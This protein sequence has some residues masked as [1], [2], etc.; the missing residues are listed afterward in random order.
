MQR[1]PSRFDQRTFFRNSRFSHDVSFYGATFRH[2]A[3]F[4]STI[5]DGDVSLSNLGFEE[6]RLT[7]YGSRIGGT[8]RVVENLEGESQLRGQELNFDRTN[9]SGLVFSAGNRQDPGEQTGPSLTD[10]DS[11]V[12]FRQANVGLLEIYRTRFN[13]RADFSIAQLG[14]L[15]LDD[16]EFSDLRLDWPVG[17]VEAPDNTFASV[18]RSYKSSGDVINERLARLD[19]YAQRAQRG[20][21][22]DRYCLSCWGRLG[23]CKAAW[24]TTGYF[25][26]LKR[27]FYTGLTL[28]VIFAVI[29]YAFFSFKRIIIKIAKPIELKLRL[30]ETPTLSHGEKYLPTRYR[31]GFKGHLVRIWYSVL[32]SLMTFAKFGAGNLRLDPKITSVHKWQRRLL[33]GFTCAVWFVWFLGYLWYSAILYTI[34]GKLPILGV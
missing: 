11:A 31:S 19:S 18:V 3:D 27:Q 28:I 21:D 2:G 20:V 26:S 25:T 17:H 30:S 4:S 34:T 9:L 23:L 8:V 5:F 33:K 22:A 7:F 29:V 24:V 16:A 32:F 1:F 12:T 10:V 14:T 13:K 15:K 6:G